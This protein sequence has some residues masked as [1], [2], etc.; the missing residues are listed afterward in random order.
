MLGIG[1]ML[2]SLSGGSENAPE[3][4]Y[5]KVIVS[6]EIDETEIE[7]GFSDGLSIVIWDNGQSCCEYRHMTT[8]DD[9]KSLVG[10]TLISIEA[11]EG[12]D[13][14]D[15]EAHETMFVEIATDKGFV[16]VVTHNE[17]NGYY[18]GFG[19]TITEKAK[20]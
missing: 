5:G 13:I 10:G 6:A 3:Q 4:Y 2:H 15:G 9:I 11:K 14:D 16:T 1:A 12:P 20:S 8:D 19:L 18:G 17:H 7:I